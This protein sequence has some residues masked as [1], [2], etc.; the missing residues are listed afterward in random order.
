M[1]PATKGSKPLDDLTYD[2][3]SILHEKSQALAAYDTYLE[4]AR[5]EPDLVRVLEEVRRHDEEDIH[6]LRSELGRLLAKGAATMAAPSAD[7][8]RAV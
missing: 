4:D 5:G 1:K 3:V 2:V 6:K 7:V 8:G